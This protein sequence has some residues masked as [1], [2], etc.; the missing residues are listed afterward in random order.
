MLNDDRPDSGYRD[1]RPPCT[2]YIK[3][4][5]ASADRE[6]V[7]RTV[8]VRTRSGVVLVAHKVER[9]NEQV[10]EV[11]VCDGLDSERAGARRRE[12]GNECRIE[13]GLAVKDGC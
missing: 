2:R 6:G 8:G 9:G 10:V 3:Y 13:E 4:I 12:S 7:D 1:P 11:L 5:A